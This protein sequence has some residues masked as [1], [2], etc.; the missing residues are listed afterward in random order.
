[1][2]GGNV[3]LDVDVEPALEL[4]EQTRD[5]TDEGARRM[6]R[7]LTVLAEGAM[8]R[9]VPVGAGRQVHTRETITTRFEN[10]G[11]T[12]IVWPTKETDSG[13]PLAEIITGDPGPWTAPPPIGPLAE[14]ADA[15]L[16]SPAG[17]WGMRQNI[18]MEGIEAFPDPFIERSVD[19]WAGDVQD[20]AGDEVGGALRR[21]GVLR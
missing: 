10:D 1:M 12:G 18:F 9:E 5:A 6:V 19:R 3:E 16:G 8:K 13:I 17:G 20:V 21:A 15:K 4:L 11:L 14:Y 2:T 7:Q